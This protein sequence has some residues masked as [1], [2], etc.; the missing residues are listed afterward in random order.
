MSANF[1]NT[2]LRLTEVAMSRGGQPLFSGV[3]FDLAP[4]QVLWVHGDNGIGKTTLLR[5]VAGFTPPE[6][7]TIAYETAGRPC[8]ASDV[9]AY[10][11][12]QAGFKAKLTAFEALSFW[13]KTHRFEGKVLDIFSTIGLSDKLSVPVANLSAGQQRRL[14]LGRLLISRKPVWIMDEPAARL[15]AEGLKLIENMISQHTDQGG[16]VL[17]ASHSRAK[18]IGKRARRLILEAAV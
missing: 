8:K 1:L 17:I 12:H 11:G 9:V 7:G 13:A 2:H 10:Q 15:D 14:G 3:S 18:A 6:I 5:I 4:S 16:S